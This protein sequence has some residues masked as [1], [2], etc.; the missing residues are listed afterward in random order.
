MRRLNNAVRVGTAATALQPLLPVA[1]LQ[2]LAV[3]DTAV[4]RDNSVLQNAQT[5][6]NLPK[7]IR[8]RVIA[9]NQALYDRAIEIR[10]RLVNQEGR[11]IWPMIWP[12]AT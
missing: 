3:G 11:G 9:L 10:E 1:D 12:S 8:V 5:I 2:E 6:L 4:V 7:G